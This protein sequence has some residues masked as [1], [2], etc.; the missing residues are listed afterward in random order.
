[1]L[2]SVV[3]SGWQIPGT[4]QYPCILTWD[5]EQ[6]KLWMSDLCTLQLEYISCTLTIALLGAYAWTPNNGH[7]TPPISATGGNWVCLFFLSG[8]L[9]WQSTAAVVS[10]VSPL[11]RGQRHWGCSLWTREPSKVGS[12]GPNFGVLVFI[13]A[14]LHTSCAILGKLSDFPE[15][16]FPHVYSKHNNII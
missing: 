9:Q 7:E 12:K 4:G 14:K 3:F 10:S 6:C 8:L 16:H 13:L 15:P 2:C 1:M 5:I 11:L